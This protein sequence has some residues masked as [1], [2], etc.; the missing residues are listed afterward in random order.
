MLLGQRDLRG[1]L[2]GDAGRCPA[3]AYAVRESRILILQK[4]QARGVEV[5][6]KPFASFVGDPEHFDFHA[7]KL[8][9]P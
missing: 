5:A 7:L 8:R 4:R 6:G 9:Y 1:G 2:G 3:T